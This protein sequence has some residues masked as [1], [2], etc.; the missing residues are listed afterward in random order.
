MNALE[1]RLD[2]EQ[3]L[4]IHRSFIVNLDR[5]KELHPWFRGGQVLALRDGTELPLGR[6]FRDRIRQY[7]EHS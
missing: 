3:F 2:P 5:I 1:P 4:R 6:A 7:L